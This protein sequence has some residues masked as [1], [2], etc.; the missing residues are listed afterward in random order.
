MEDH[1][2]VD[3]PRKV[4]FVSN[5][6]EQVD[7]RLEV[8]PL[9]TQVLRGTLGNKTEEEDWGDRVMHKIQ[10]TILQ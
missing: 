1:A 9:Q 6:G 7:L 4:V 8:L 10:G 3:R 2:V 5:G